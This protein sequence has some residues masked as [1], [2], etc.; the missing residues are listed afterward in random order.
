M[1]AHAGLSL[2][3]ETPTTGIA[4]TLASL[5]IRLVRVLGWNRFGDRLGSIGLPLLSCLGLAVLFAVLF[6]F[7]RR[8]LRD[9]VSLRAVLFTVP[10][11]LLLFLAYPLVVFGQWFF[12]RYYF[13]LAIVTLLFTAAFGRAIVQRW[14]P[15]RIAVLVLVFVGA[16]LLNTGPSLLFPVPRNFYQQAERIR[17]TLPP[18]AVVGA[19]QAGHLGFFCPQRVVNLDG[20]VN[21]LAYHAL[22]QRRVLAFARSHGVQFITEWPALLDLLVLKRSDPELRKRLVRVEPPADWATPSNAHGWAT[23]MFEDAEKREGR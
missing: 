21:G 10:A 5:S 13:P 18:T 19:V 9:L 2:V 17:S 14:T 7:R 15:V 12:G 22:E 3:R 8:R 1:V 4:D 16:F 23:W 20:K 11:G 6:W